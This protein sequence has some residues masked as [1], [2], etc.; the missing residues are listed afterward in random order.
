[1][2]YADPL[3]PATPG[4]G[5]FAGQGDD[6]IREF[7]RALIQRLETFFADVDADPMVPIVGIIPDAA[8]TGLAHINTQLATFFVDPLAVTLVPKDNSIPQSA[9]IGGGS[10]GEGSVNTAALQ[11]RSVTEPKLADDSVSVRTLIDDAVTGPAIKNGE[12]ST[13]KLGDGA[14]TL[15]K[16]NSEVKDVVYTL[17]V[18][19]HVV[20]GP[21]VLGGNDAHP[22]NSF[23]TVDLPL[24]GLVAGLPVFA[25]ISADPGLQVGNGDGPRLRLA[26]IEVYTL[27]DKVRVI[28]QNIE[29]GDGVLNVGGAEINVFILHPLSVTYP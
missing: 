18:L 5:N 8:V 19:N 7:K 2:A 20:P 3:D 24:S 21:L 15:S 25:S 26:Y 9:I 28:L 14:A 4:D 12:V 27:V 17:S 6:R 23:Y 29:T 22:E 1:M 11:D 10:A 16:L 13:P